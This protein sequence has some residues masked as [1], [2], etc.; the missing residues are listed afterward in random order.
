MIFLIVVLHTRFHVSASFAVQDR[1]QGKYSMNT[2][3][4]SFYLINCYLF[5]IWLHVNNVFCSLSTFW[6]TIDSIWTVVGCSADCWTWTFTSL[7]VI[8]VNRI[9]FSR[10]RKL[11]GKCVQVIALTRRFFLL[12]DIHYIVE[13]GNIAFFSLFLLV[14]IQCIHY[15]NNNC[16][17]SYTFSIITF[18]W[19][20]FINLSLHRCAVIICWPLFLVLTFFMIIF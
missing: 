1:Q 10:K 12:L 20:L 14:S 4:V 2:Q 15:N 7:N 16:C 11:I 3:S 17:P 19:E 9:Q 13:W 6:Y 8:D 5:S 18:N